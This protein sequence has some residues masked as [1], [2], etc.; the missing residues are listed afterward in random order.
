M[1]RYQSKN[2]SEAA[3]PSKSPKST[4][5]TKSKTAKKS[6]T[7]IKKTKTSNKK[8]KSASKPASKAAK[9]KVVETEE[10][11]DWEVEK[12]IDVRFNEDG[13]KNFLI[14]WKGCDPTQ[15]TWEPE[16]NV[17]SPDLVN[18]FMNKTDDADASAP[19]KKSRK[20]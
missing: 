1:K 4:K 7:P 3:S 18:A 6:K 20:A 8:S 14:R 15:D 17:N 9:S 19:K 16:N 12:I 5:S 13:S 2:K 11:Q 10:E